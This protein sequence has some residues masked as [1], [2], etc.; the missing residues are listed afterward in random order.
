MSRPPRP[1]K[2][3]PSELVKARTE[4]LR[5]ILKNEAER[6]LRSLHKFPA[7]PRPR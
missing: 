5:W 2:A 6:R 4:L 3:T 1:A 7:E